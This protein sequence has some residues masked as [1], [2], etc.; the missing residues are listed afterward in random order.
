MSDAADMCSACLVLHEVGYI[1][2]PE[3]VVFAKFKCVI[4][5]VL[6]TAAHCIILHIVVV[7]YC[8]YER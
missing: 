1:Q 3:S 5:T 2:P 8:S 4:K 6:V 7:F